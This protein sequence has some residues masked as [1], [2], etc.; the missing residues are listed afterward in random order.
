M[1]QDND[2]SKA[3]FSASSAN[4]YWLEKDPRLL[5][6]L[7]AMERAENWVV[8]GNQKAE[9]ALKEFFQ[10]AQ[11]SDRT[12]QIGRMSEILIY[13]MANLGVT[14]AMHMLSWLDSIAFGLGSKVV[15]SARRKSDDD[16][17]EFSKIMLERLNVLRRTRVLS[18]VFQTSRMMMVLRS[19]EDYDEA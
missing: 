1:L 12:A 2:Q 3:E 19:L 18:R 4:Q 6:I 8:D 11:S 17:T 10:K 7:L 5:H 16:Q 13:V 14:R 9:K 15:Q